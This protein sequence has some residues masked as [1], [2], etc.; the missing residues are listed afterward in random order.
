MG[1]GLECPAVRETTRAAASSNMYGRRD[2]KASSTSKI[3]M[4]SP[5]EMDSFYIDKPRLE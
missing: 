3:L 4:G 5:A 1:S 2:R